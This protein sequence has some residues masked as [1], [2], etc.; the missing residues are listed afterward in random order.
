MVVNLARS[1]SKRILSSSHIRE[2]QLL[3]EGVLGLRH[4]FVLQ[5][6]PFAYL[7]V[8][9]C[10]DAEDVV[11]RLATKKRAIGYLK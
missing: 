5:E 7:P 8:D 4:L 10:Q 9:A 2:D 6:F 1:R 3:G 11:G